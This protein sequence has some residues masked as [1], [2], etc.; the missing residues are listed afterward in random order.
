M[1][2]AL[3]RPTITRT[4]PALVWKAAS[5]WSAALL[6]AGSGAARAQAPHEK[7]GPGEADAAW[8]LG[9]AVGSVQKPYRG[10]GR[11][12]IA[13]PLLSYENRYVRLSS[14]NVDLKLPSLVLSASSRLHFGLRARLFSEGGYESSDSPALAGMAERKS[15][16]WIGPTVK[17]DN[18]FAD[19]QLELLADASGRSK[20][21][22]VS[23][24]LERRWNLGPNVTLVPHAG[25][26]W[27]DENYVNYYYGVLDNEAAP[28]RPAYAG[29][30]AVNLVASLAAVYRWDRQQS[31]VLQAGAKSLGPAIRNSPVV[32]RSAENRVMLGYQY[33][34]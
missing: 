28:G 30:S 5:A 3:P 13:L 20:G 32:G 21:R 8:A 7:P 17:W 16:A 34:F 19:V 24:G 14:P 18:G 29:P 10:M 1:S 22:R 27:V 4:V 12:A 15:G 2:I 31:L 6:L 33:R 11:K 9:L 25:V 26:E 23:L